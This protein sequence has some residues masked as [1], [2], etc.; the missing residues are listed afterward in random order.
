METKLLMGNE[1][2]ALGAIAAGV[3]MVAGYPGTPS[4]CLLYTSFEYDYR[5]KRLVF[6]PNIAS[7]FRFEKGEI[8]PM[9]ESYR[10]RMIHPADQSALR[11]FLSHG[12]KLAAGMPESTMLRFLDKSGEYRWMDCQGQLL[13]DVYKR[14]QR[15]SCGAG[16]D[17]DL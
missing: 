13:R 10:F 12:E 17:L 15:L 9:D 11:E 8:R 4:T 7:R 1:A 14:Q 5:T 16:G 2:I 6:T 3:Q